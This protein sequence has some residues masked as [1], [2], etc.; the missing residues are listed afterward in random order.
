MSRPL[1]VIVRGIGLLG[2]GLPNWPDGAPRLAAPSGWTMAPTQVPPPNRLPP[3][4]RRRAGT[5]VKAAI[6]AADEACAAAG[7]DPRELPSVF[8]SSTGEPA[9]CHALCEALAAP[10]RLVSPTRF[11]N[12]VHNAPGGYWH[13]ATASM[14]ASTSLGAYDASFAM[15]L[16]EAAVQCH[17]TQR[18]VLLVASDVPYLEPLHAKRPV[19]D[20]FSVAFVLAPA[21]A[22]PRL[23][24][25][26]LGDASASAAGGGLEAVRTGIPAARALPLLEAIAAKRTA[27]LVIEGLPGL[28]L[29]VGVTP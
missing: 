6:V 4:E 3:T 24:I 5:V 15:G 10:E 14:Q 11:T 23:A 18:A 29:G 19:L 8:T 12:S 21:G 28:A 16:L 7:L 1:E 20:V 26:T 2:P 25:S 9:N 13:I 17:A 22:G 27:Q